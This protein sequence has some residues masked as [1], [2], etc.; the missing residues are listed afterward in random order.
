MKNLSIYAIVFILFL[1]PHSQ[2]K[3]SSLKMTIQ[4]LPWEEVTKV[5]PK[6]AKFDIV[7][8]ETGQ[9]F[10]VQRRAGSDHADVQ[11]ITHEDTKIMK[12]IYSGSWSWKRRAIIVA[13]DNQLVAASMN[14]MP[15]GAGALRNGFPGHFCVHFLN[16]TTHSSSTPDMAHQIMVF[17]AGGRIK[18]YLLTLSN[19]HLL[20]AL[21][22][23]I[24]N[25][26]QSILS[27]ILS[28]SDKHDFKII[29]T[30]DTIEYIHTEKMD[31]S[32][33][34]KKFEVKSKVYIKNAGP[35]VLT[36]SFFFV[37]D[38]IN[39]S[40]SILSQNLTEQL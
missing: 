26:D 12:E 7:D 17:K 37:K 38:P 39:N 15:H 36:I 29:S 27:L 8:V 14:G 32:E 31:V 11:P 6:G 9:R 10:S 1:Y 34:F 40:W 30:I 28:Q 22:A 4:L 18:E 35:I 5:I 24:N 23:V 16:S 2:A 33:L 21:A 3:A 20:E 19:Q 25:D 13:Y